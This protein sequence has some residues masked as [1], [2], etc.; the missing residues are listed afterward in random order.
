MVDYKKGLRKSRPNGRIWCK[1][2]KS[3]K[4]DTQLDTEKLMAEYNFT[5]QDIINE[6]RERRRKIRGKRVLVIS[7]YISSSLF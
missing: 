2:V 1:V 7:A 6:G 5:S 4:K 3:S